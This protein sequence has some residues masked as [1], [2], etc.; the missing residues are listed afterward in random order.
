MNDCVALCHMELCI[1][2]VQVFFGFLPLFSSR[3]VGTFANDVHIGG[4]G[5]VDQALR[6]ML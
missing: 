6:S 1:N 5:K 3:S 2:D 4:K